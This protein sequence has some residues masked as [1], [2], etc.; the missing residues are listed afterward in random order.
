VATLAT[1]LFCGAA[2]AAVASDASLRASVQAASKMIAA[3][4]HSVSLNATLRHPRL[5]TASAVRFR[6]DA[7]RAHTSI[8]RQRPS[9]AKG[10]QAKGLALRAF[11]NYA[12]AGTRWAASGRARVRGH[13]ALA[14]TLARRAAV[15]AKHGNRLLIA[16]GKILG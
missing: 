9:T 6:K 13:R 2:R 16:A 3:D 1:V 10:I 14:T 12:A 11:T 15:Y 5:M 7:L 4:A 8:A